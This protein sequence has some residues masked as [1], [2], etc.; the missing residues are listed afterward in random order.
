VK[1]GILA[2]LFDTGLASLATLAVG[3]FAARSLSPLEL[4]S[5]AIVFAAFLAAATVPMQAICV[6][7]EVAALSL[8]SKDRILLLPRTIRLSTPVALLSAVGMCGWVSLVPQSAGHQ[9][10]VALTLTGALAAFVSPIQ[11]HLRRLLHLADRSWQAAAVSLVQVVA[12]VSAI[13]LGLHSGVPACWLA[14]GALAL[15]NAISLVIGVAM[16]SGGI[17]APSRVPM[18]HGRDLLRSGRSLLL[19]GLLPTVTGFVTAVLISRLAGAEALGH[20]EGARIITQPLLVMSVGLSAFLGPRSMEAGHG[21]QLRAARRVSSRFI[22][23]VLLWGIP[24]LLLV[25]PRWNGSML[26]HLVPNAY[27]VSGLVLAMGL[28]NLVNGT[29]IPYRSEL[30]GAGRNATLV[31]IEV[32]GNVARVGL[33][34]L[35]GVLG[36]FTVPAG[37]AALGLVRWV[38]YGRALEPH[39]VVEVPVEKYR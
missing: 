1:P 39:Y 16:A 33:A 30:L 29:V 12:V 23:L 20:A 10:I 11:D 25:G 4:G 31:G 35:A 18:L 27:Y 2:G 22:G 9:V 3:L 32:T 21:R 17:K 6:P 36:S 37:L 38:G 15:A 14:F 26:P 19:I 7:A 24:Y 34:G 8:S 28:A 5:Y 13:L